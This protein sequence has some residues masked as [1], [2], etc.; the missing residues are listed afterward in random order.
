M[1]RLRRTIGWLFL[2]LVAIFLVSLLGANLYVQSQATQQRI[3]QELSQRLKMPLQIQRISVTPWGGLELSGI[4]IPQSNDAQAPPFLQ[5]KHFRLRVRLRSIFWRPLVIKEVALIAPA[6]IWPQNESGEWRVPMT[7]TPSEAQV[8]AEEEEPTVSTPDNL[9]EGTPPQKESKQTKPAVVASTAAAPQIKKIRLSDGSFHFLDHEKRNIAL[10]DGVQFSSSMRDVNSI[11]GQAR[12]A[13]IVLRDRVFLSALRSP[14]RYD[15]SELELSGITAQIAKGQLTG[16]FSMQ[17]QAEDSP[18]TVHAS[19]HRVQADQLVAEAGGSREIIRGTLEGTLDATGKTADPDALTGSGTILLQNGHVQQFA[20]LAAL[21]QLLQIEE[22]TQLDLEQAE[23]KYHLAGNTVL[24]DE[25]LLRSP[26]LRLTATG[27][28]SLRGKL[29]LDSVLAINEKIRSQL[30]RGIRENFVATSEPGQY[31]LQF[32]VGGTVDKPKTD[33]MERA[34]GAD[35]K[36]LGG[37]I[38]AL[39]GH[40]SKKKKNA[41]AATPSATA[42]P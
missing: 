25:L 1:F 2:V 27:S 34:V 8:Q 5:A 30:F 42:T 33:L 24:V 38:D 4:T 10:F 41:D 9:P 16:D 37:V 23:A 15:P 14:I 28:V 3:Q 26:N 17:P 35:L 32:H 31:A 22:L 36:D 20:V 29:A 21:G 7:E 18:F 6:V 11:R 13:K 39:L 40:K 19:F 12:I